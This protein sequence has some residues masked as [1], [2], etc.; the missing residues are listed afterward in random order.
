VSEL[1]Q[2][3]V[4]LHKEVGIV[5]DLMGDLVEHEKLCLLRGGFAIRAILRFLHNISIQFNI[6]EL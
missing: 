2:L 5:S 1:S 3:F 6:S 4:L